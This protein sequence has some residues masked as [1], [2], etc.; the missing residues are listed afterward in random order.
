VKRAL[1]SG[2]V[3]VGVL[4]A[5]SAPVGAGLASTFAV[6]P[7]QAPPGAEVTVMGVC[8][9]GQDFERVF[10]YLDLPAGGFVDL[11]DFAITPAVP[12][13]FTVT[14]PA[15]APLGPTTMGKQCARVD[16]GG[17]FNGGEATQRVDFVV[18]EPPPV[19]TTTTTSTTAVSPST[20]TT[21]A[22]AAPATV[23]PTF[24]G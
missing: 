19:E 9:A 10:F 7:D 22:S 21:T 17:E 5:A 18:V 8:E 14:I 15:D 6:D 13:E 23:T 3:A 4:L 11:G 24:T 20:T 16:A 1:I 2:V 12:W